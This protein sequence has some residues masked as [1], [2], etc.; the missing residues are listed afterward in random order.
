MKCTKLAA[1]ANRHLNSVYQAGNEQSRQSIEMNDVRGGI[2]SQDSTEPQFRLDKAQLRRDAY[3]L[4]CCMSQYRVKQKLDESFLR[5]LIYGLITPL[6][7]LER[8]DDSNRN[9]ARLSRQRKAQQY[10]AEL[11]M[12]MT[13]RLRELRRRGIY[14]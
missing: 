5:I 8:V 2:P 7:D 4:L 14:P 9:K 10:T 6:Q 11:L 13:N 3:Y 1:T 12:E